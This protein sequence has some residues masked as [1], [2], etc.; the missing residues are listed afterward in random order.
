[1]KIIEKIMDNISEEVEGAW[2]YAEKSLECKARGNTGRAA[3]YKDMAYDEIKHS[4]NL[5]E[6]GEADIDALRRVH[7]V[8]IE[9]EEH[10]SAFKKKFHESI[11]KIKLILS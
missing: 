11:A 9:D 2:E 10:W 7:P 5:Y 6:F 1:M 4:E 8:P 3:K